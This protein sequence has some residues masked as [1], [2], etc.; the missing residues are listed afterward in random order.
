M[1]HNQKQVVLIVDDESNNIYVLGSMLSA[2][3][4]EV[5][6]AIDGKSALEFAK[7][8]EK[9]D[10]ILLDIMMPDMDGYEVCRQLKMEANTKNIPIIFMTALQDE[11]SETKGLMLGAIDYIK[12]PFSQAIVKARVKN[13]LELKMHRDILESLCELDELTTIPNRRHFEVI[14]AKEIARAKRLEDPLSCLMIDIDYFKNY[15]DNYGHLAGDECL[16]KVANIIKSTLPRS[17]DFIARYGGEE[18]IVLLP[19]TEYDGAIAVANKIVTAIQNANLEHKFSLIS[20]RITVSIGSSTATKDGII[21]RNSLI[22]RADKALYIAKE[23]GRNRV[24]GERA[25]D[26]DEQKYDL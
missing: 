15:N 4:Y 17:N 24:I 16:K 21:S 14:F 11:D 1:E 22:D 6:T 23:K 26:A 3:G 5:K 19:H 2:A 20:D 8:S 13:H 25:I 12:K 18:F 7:N 9:L 10:L